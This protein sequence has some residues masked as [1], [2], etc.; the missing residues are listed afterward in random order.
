M[1][2]APVVAAVAPAPAKTTKLHKRKH[3]AQTAEEF[4]LSLL[5]GKSLITGDINKAWTAAGRT[6]RADNTLYIL[7]K[8]NAV[9]RVPLKDGQGS[10]YS[11]A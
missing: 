1:I 7:T 5:A 4:V 3:F 8:K 6:G 10:T 2:P 9:E 11:V